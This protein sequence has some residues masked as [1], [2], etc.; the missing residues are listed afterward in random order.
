M[1][2]SIPL[3]LA[4]VLL[5]A[6]AD[7][8][9]PTTPVSTDGGIAVADGRGSGHFIRSATYGVL[10]GTTLT[11]YFKEAGLA[12]GSIQTIRL[13]AFASATYEC[14][15]DGG[16]HPRAANK[17][18]VSG[19]VSASQNFPVDDNGNLTGSISISA[20]G[21]GGF[22]CPNG[23]S[24]IGPTAVSFSGVVIRDITSGASMS[25]GNFN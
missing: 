3:A 25:L 2:R 22:A 14:W 20:P 6:C 8:V 24:M 10:S 5:S 15:N 17:E 21:P 4:L 18:T 9:P 19:D 16:K 7:G 23:Q 11:A 1:K 12:E 13:S